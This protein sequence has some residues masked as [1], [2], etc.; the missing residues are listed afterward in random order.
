MLFERAL[1]LWAISLT[2][3]FAAL[4]VKVRRW[5]DRCSVP[6]QLREK[7]D[8]AAG[9]R[10]RR[11]TRLA[12]LCRLFDWRALCAQCL[13]LVEATFG[14]VTGCAWT[15]AIA[16]FTALSKNTL[17]AP[18]VA[19]EDV[20][21]A[22]ALTLVALAWLVVHA[23]RDSGASASEHD[24]ARDHFE[25]AFATNA[26]VF[27]VGWAWVI[28]LRDATSLVFLAVWRVAEGSAW[29]SDAALLAEGA[30]VAL[31][32][33]ALTL[34]VLWAQFKVQ[35]FDRIRQTLASL[36]SPSC[37]RRVSDA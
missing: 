12:A 13:S 14:W 10:A 30:T 33:V 18:S 35:P 8:A 36:P 1:L 9:G 6:P 2:G 29:A 4:N 28:A 31:L 37:S 22:A 32:G 25:A 3:L 15:D 23:P 19:A 21:V 24:L 16:R 34:A 26:F 17:Q 27:V 11:C 5:R 20:R 7:S